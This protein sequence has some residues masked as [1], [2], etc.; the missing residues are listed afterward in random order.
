MVISWFL[1]PIFTGIIAGFVYFVTRLAVLRRERSV[2]LAYY[3]FPLIVGITIF[4]V[5]LAIFLKGVSKE[6]LDW[7]V[8]SSCPTKARIG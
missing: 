7:C 5:L 2:M 6:E 4:I 8:L 1:S 3:V